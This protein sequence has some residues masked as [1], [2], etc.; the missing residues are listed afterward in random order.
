MQNGRVAEAK[1][2]LASA[3]DLEAEELPAIHETTFLNGESVRIDGGRRAADKW[4]E[5]VSVLWFASSI[6]DGQHSNSYIQIGDEMVCLLNAELDGDDS[7]FRRDQ[8]CQNDPERLSLPVS[9]FE[10]R[11]G[12]FMAVRTH[13][14]NS[15]VPDCQMRVPRRRHQ[16][17]TELALCPP[18][19]HPAW[20]GGHTGGKALDGST[21]HTST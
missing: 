6:C 7:E 12:H 5:T 15:T 21:A 10:R 4:F 18:R 14:T 16:H 20:I 3:R 9:P 2:A 11:C 17:S 8:C 13:I 1:E 19:C